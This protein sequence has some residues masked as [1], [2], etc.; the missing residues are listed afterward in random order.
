VVRQGLAAWRR[1]IF[2]GLAVATVSV[3]TAGAAASRT[4]PQ[5]ATAEYRVAA[6]SSTAVD[7]QPL[8]DDSSGAPTHQKAMGQL[9]ETLT[10]VLVGGMLLGL[11][12]AVRKTTT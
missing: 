2:V 3:G 6:A 12:A 9:P 7:P 1:T 10:L 4:D 5:P 11:A 8:A